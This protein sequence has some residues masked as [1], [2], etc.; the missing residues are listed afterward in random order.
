[1]TSDKQ[2]GVSTQF[3][4]IRLGRP[5]INEISVI[6]MYLFY[7]LSHIIIFV[8]N[9]LVRCKNKVIQKKDISI[10][11]LLYLH[12]AGSLTWITTAALPAPF[13]SLSICSSKCQC[14]SLSPCLLSCAKQEKIAIFLYAHFKRYN[15]GWRSLKFA[16]EMLQSPLA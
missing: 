5:V 9:T 4:S 1:M 15:P 6:F 14:L 8:L 2:K 3:S 12:V 16:K 10:V 11:W 13:P 7:K